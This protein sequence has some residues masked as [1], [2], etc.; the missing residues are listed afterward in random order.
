MARIEPVAF[1]N[2]LHLPCLS[3][4][5]ALMGSVWQFSGD[6]RAAKVEEVGFVSALSAAQEHHGFGYCLHG[7]W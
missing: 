3:A 6:W 5:R 1:V 2:L 4:L 7:G